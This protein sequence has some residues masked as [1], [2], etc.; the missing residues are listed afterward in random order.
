[1]ARRQLDGDWFLRGI[2]PRVVTGA[3]TYLESSY[4]F[5]AVLDGPPGT[6]TIG[7]AS[8]A[9]DRATLHVGPR[10][11][12]Q[13]GAYTVLNGCTL[14]CNDAVTIGDHC[15]IAWGAVISDTWTA[16]TD[17]AERA[18]HVMKAAQ[19]PDR[20]LAPPGPTR[21]VTLADN[22]WIGFDAVLLP[23]TTIGRGAVVSSRSVVSGEVPPYAIVVGTPGRVVRMLSPTDTP[24]A[25][26]IA[27]R[28]HLRG[29]H[30]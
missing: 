20:Y 15:M 1:M 17:R 25:R 26:T 21:C 24:E 19:H 10:G 13:V 4:G 14:V 11:V 27:L 29:V 8:G 2:P 12:L 23:G 9:Y 16:G 5:D 18:A 30:R 6:V 7:D 3:D 22:V 28:E